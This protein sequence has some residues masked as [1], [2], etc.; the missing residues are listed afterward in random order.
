LTVVVVLAAG[1]GAVTAVFTI[2]DRV[3]LRSLPHDDAHRMVA[4]GATFPGREWRTDASDLQYLAGFSLGNFLDWQGSVTS[5]ERMGAIES[6]SIMMPDRGNGPELASANAV[7]PGLFDILGMQPT[8]G[9]TF[10]ENEYRAAAPQVAMVS[11]DTWQTRYGG[12]PDVVGRTADEGGMEIIGVLPQGFTLPEAIAS[13]AEF[14]MPIRTDSERY[15]NR[16][17]RSLIGLGRLAPGAT[18]DRA[19]EELDAIAARSAEEHPE[20]NVYPDGRRLGAGANLLRRET[21]GGAG[22]PLLLFALGSVLLLAI[23][24]LNA[25]NLVLTRSLGRQGEIALRLALGAG[26]ARVVRLLVAESL[27]LSLAGGALGIGLGYGGVKAFR[28]LGPASIPRMAEIALDG[29]IVLLALGLTVVTG[30]LTAVLPTARLAEGGLAHRIRASAPIRKT[31]SDWSWSVGGQVALSLLLTVAAGLLMESFVRIRSFEPGFDP[32]SALTFQQG[33]KRPGTEGMATHALWDEVVEVVSAAPGYEEVAAASN[34]PFQS[35]NW[36]PAVLLE[37]EPPETQRSG[38]AGY[39]V[40]PNYFRVLGIPVLEGRTFDASDRPESLPVAIANQAF[41]DMHLGGESPLGR[42]IRFREGEVLQQLR[43]VGVVGNAIQTRVEEGVRPA[44]YIP[45]TQTDWPMAWVFARTGADPLYGVPGIRRALGAVNPYIPPLRIGTMADQ[46]GR[47]QTNPRFNAAVAG[48]F[49]VLALLLAAGGLYG[50]LSFG[51]GRRLKEIGIRMTLGAE[52][53]SVVGMILRQGL[54][55]T[56]GGILTG[57]AAAVVTTRLLSTFL[58]DV[59]H[60]SPPVFAVSALTLI[61][62]AAAASIGPA[63]R[64]VRVDPAATLGAE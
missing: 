55:V 24:I 15:E 28:I 37:G 25:S 57:L 45:H 62:V 63:R 58:F 34:L 3:L 46:I 38:V 26:R 19:R 2:A 49:G 4:L 32:S 41:V 12:D 31:K 48:A 47:T 22:R 14:W 8:L 40:T 6:R 1:L 53:R 59:G 9:R 16:G 11:Y 54:K 33:L 21:I 36:A 29:R 39:V 43:V 50:A 51:V 44:V 5:L 42:T 20:G 61:A 23:A 7:T 10:Q 52:P 64:A 17:R 30:L 60:L 18:I 56:L 13:A 35:P 27:L